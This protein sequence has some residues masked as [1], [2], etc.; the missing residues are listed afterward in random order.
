MNRL[1]N[2]MANVLVSGKLR[3]GKNA[4][5]TVVNS[6]LTE[7][8]IDLAELAAL[9]GIAAADLAKIDGITNGTVAAGKAAVVDANKDIGDFRN[10]DAVNID[11]GAS[12]A[13]GTVDV[14]P[15]TA[16]KGKLSLTCSDQTGDTIVTVN[17]DE[18][19]QATTVHFADPGAAAS[20]VAQSTAALT[21]AEVDVL[22]GAASTNAVAGKAAITDATGILALSNNKM[23]TEAGAGITGGTG[24]VYKTSVSKLGG[25]IKTTI[26]LD[27]T[28][29]SSSTTDLDIIGQG[30]SAAHLGQITAARNGTVLTGRITCLE[31]PV[32]GVTDIDMYSAAEA[33]G[34][35]DGAIADL[36]ETALLTAGAAWTLGDVKV[37]TAVPAANEYLYLTGG[38]A[39][40]AAAYTAGK[41][42]VEIEGYDA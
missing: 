17:A 41:F 18:M 28:G 10:L 36:A 7:S 23:A 40:T 16:S 9:D 20:Y 37:F 2:K 30:A 1:W 19:G 27:L 31:A 25:I 34:V 33:T 39:G 13:A 4:S 21:L 6:D 15:A 24:T 26:L 12:G 42:L 14:F 22:D 29:L 11:A 8:V 35:F 32:G 5:L 3:L 38:A